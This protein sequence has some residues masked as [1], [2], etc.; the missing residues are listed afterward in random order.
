[1]SS[2]M[3]PLTQLLLLLL[4]LIFY[5]II[6]AIKFKCIRS[7]VRLS[8]VCSLTSEQSDIKLRRSVQRLVPECSKAAQW[9]SEMEKMRN[10][11]QRLWEIKIRQWSWFMITNTMHSNEKKREKRITWCRSLTSSNRGNRVESICAQHARAPYTIEQLELDLAGP[12]VTTIAS[13]QI[14]SLSEHRNV[15]A[16]ELKLI[17]TD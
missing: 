10:M 14:D 8:N 3:L 13:L 12:L 16:G 1:M 11:Q 7:F 15:W 9:P 2:C 6:F 17:E 5:I 4:L